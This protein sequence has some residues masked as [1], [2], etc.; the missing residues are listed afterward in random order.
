MAAD[1]PGGRGGDGPRRR[2]RGGADRHR[3]RRSA[4]A[5]TCSGA[6]AHER[7][8]VRALD[9]REPD[10]AGDRRASTSRWSPPSTGSRPGSAARPRWPADLVVAAESASVPAGLRP[11]RADARRRR[12]GHRRGL[13]RAGPG[14]ADGA[15]RRAAVGPRGARLRADHPRRPDAE[16]A[17]RR[18]SSR[19]ASPPVP[20]SRTPR[21]RRRS[22]PPPSPSLEAALERER[23]GQRVLLRTADVAEGMRAFGEAGRRCSAGSESGVARAVTRSHRRGTRVGRRVRGFV[24]NPDSR[25][26]APQPVP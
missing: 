24:P 26:S 17:D 6:D 7:F 22:T 20:R 1:W 16:F 14:D 18:A 12:V 4:P 9:A 13:D 21:P 10:G 15:A 3:R 8:D 19:A 2:P 5:P 25:W 23:S 11:D